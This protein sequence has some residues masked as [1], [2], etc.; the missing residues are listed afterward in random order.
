MAA[1]GMAAKGMVAKG[2]V[3]KGMAAK[4]MAAKGM[5]AKGMVGATRIVHSYKDTG[6]LYIYC[7]A[8]AL[9]HARWMEG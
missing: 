6:C 1:K 3:A 8:I 4:G 2:M 9:L 5:A 7:T